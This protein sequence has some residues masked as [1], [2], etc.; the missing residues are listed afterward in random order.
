M[1]VG[2]D[3]T[4][5]NDGVFELHG[6]NIVGSRNRRIRTDGLEPTVRSYEN[7]ATIDRSAFN[8]EN[9]PGGEPPR[10]HVSEAE[11]ASGRLP[12]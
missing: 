9:P 2:I 3:Q 6:R 11:W 12:P 7:G 5:E 4:G 8:G 10:P 1:S